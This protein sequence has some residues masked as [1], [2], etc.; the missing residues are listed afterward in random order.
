MYPYIK[1]GD[2]ITIIIDNKA[3]TIDKTHLMFDKIVEAIKNNEWDSIQPM[4]DVKEAIVDYSK[5]RIT[6]K[7]NEIFWDGEIFHNALS[8]RMISMMKEGFSIEPML[9]FMENLMNNPSN[10]SITELYS[11]L[12]RCNLPITPDGHFLAYKKVRDNYKDVHS[13][14][15]DNRLA[16]MLSAEEKSTTRKFGKVNVAVENGNTV[17][18][19]PRNSVDDDRRNECSNGLHFCSKEY[20]SHFSGERILILKVNPRDVV[21][22]PCDYNYAKARCCRY[23]VIGE[24]Q[25]S[26]DVAFK[27]PVQSYAYDEWEDDEWEDDEYDGD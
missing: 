23:E 16:G 25:S 9:L 1:Q 7:D 19:M 21:S 10:N 24:L 3:Y 15:V 27:K 2:N 6:I 4:L 8:E 5:G 14:T 13:N 17:V 26:P 11:F 12:A 22:V 20:L 18:Y